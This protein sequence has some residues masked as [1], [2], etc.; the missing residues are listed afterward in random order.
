M[1]KKDGLY[2]SFASR[3]RT[4]LQA[5]G[6][7][8]EVVGESRLEVHVEG[9]PGAIP[10]Q[11]F[12]DVLRTSLVLLDKLE[13]AENLARGASGRWLIEELRNES[14]TAV[15]VRPGEV[16]APL[17]LVDG[18]HQ[19]HDTAALPSYFS[20]D[21]ARAVAQV[22]AHARQPGVTGVTYRTL[23]PNLEIVEE[24][25]TEDVASNAL[26]AVKG[27]DIAIGSVT[28]VLDVI[29]LRRGANKVSLYD[30]DTRRAVQCRFPKDLFET[31]KE[32]LGRRV[33]ALGELTRNERGQAL[34]VKID[35]VEVLPEDITVPSVDELVGIAEWYTGERTTDEY[36]RWVRH[37]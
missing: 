10:A 11:A 37:E 32:A 15:L 1:D 17:R 22:R 6:Q 3:S 2:R 16:N 27:A 36:L 14:A 35:E 34:R 13:R 19:L 5:N 33:R 29:N 7:G 31:M 9:R 18:V 8:R 23:T 25:V 21:I 20:P 30:D 26:A 12:L 24:Q 28:G 4:N